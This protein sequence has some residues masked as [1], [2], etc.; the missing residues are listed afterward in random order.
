MITLII[1]SLESTE[2]AFVRV[3]RAIRQDRQSGGEIRETNEYAGLRRKLFDLRFDTNRILDEAN[4]IHEYAQK[5]MNWIN[6][7][8]E[9]Q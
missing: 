3:D 1:S 4:R 7:N 9:K 8:E 6:T 2:R 5:A